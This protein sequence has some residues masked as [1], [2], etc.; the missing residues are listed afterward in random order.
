MVGAGADAEGD[1]RVGVSELAAGEHH[2]QAL[3]GE[4][5]GDLLPRLLPPA[6]GHGA[7]GTAI[8]A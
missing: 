8:A 2:V 3:G 1:V 5:R 4:L 7:V 6:S